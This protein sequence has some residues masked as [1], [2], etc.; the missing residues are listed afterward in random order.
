MSKV[1]TPIIPEYRLIEIIRGYVAEHSTE[2]SRP[3]M[4]AE[5]HLL[6]ISRL[7]VDEARARLQLWELEKEAN[8]K[9]AA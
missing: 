4:N 3:D 2:I 5:R 1:Y 6:G 7:V 8:D 9:G